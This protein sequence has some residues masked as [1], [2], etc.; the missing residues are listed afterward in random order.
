M[1][2]P[3]ISYPTFSIKLPSNGRKISFRPFLVKEEKILLFAKESG[4]AEEI[5]DAITQIINNCVVDDE[6]DVNNF[7]TFDM[8]YIFIQ[9]RNKSVGNIIVATVK[10]AEDGK[11][12]KVEV[13]LEAVTLDSF[14]GAKKNNVVELKDSNKT[15]FKLR[16]PTSRDLINAAKHA[17]NDK[18][19]DLV[20]E[21]AR[22]CITDL[23]DENNV[24][25]WDENTDAEKLE[26]LN[27]IKGE[28]Y[29]E[30]SNFFGDAPSLNHEVFYKNAAGN[31]RSVIFRSLEDFFAF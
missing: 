27:S 17:K 7:T 5:Y 9:L 1:S 11:E 24:Y 19:P 4:E 26:F 13:D 18:D 20:L 2:L 29:A 10:D 30:M 8:E 23:S 16:Y 28:A 21:L 3:K 25:V 14:E 6:F 31:Q 12:Y 22:F 15:I